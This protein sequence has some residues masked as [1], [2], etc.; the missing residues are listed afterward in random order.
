MNK[1]FKKNFNVF[2]NVEG[3]SRKEL[4]IVSREND[5]E[6]PPSAV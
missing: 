2:H 6:I 1:K 4:E 5:D 3:H